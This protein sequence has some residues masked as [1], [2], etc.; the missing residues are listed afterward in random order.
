MVFSSL[1]F[2]YVFLPLTLAVYHL[3]FF[4][5]YKTRRPAFITLSNLVLLLASL[6][7]Y[8]WGQQWYLFVMLFSTFLD[9][10][11]A[12]LIGYGLYGRLGGSSTGRRLSRTGLVMSIA[13]NLAL[14]GY[15]KYAGFFARGVQALGEVISGSGGSFFHLGEIVLPIGISFYTFQTLSYTIDVYRGVVRPNKNLVD[16]ACYVTMF[17]Q[18]VAGPIVRYRDICDQLRHRSIGVAKFWRGI[19]RFS[20]GLAKKVLIANTIAV[21]ADDLFG[22]PVGTLTMEAAWQGAFF[23]ALQIYFDFSGYSDMAIGLGHLL[24]F[25][26]PENFNYPYLADSMRDFWRRWH[27]SLSTWFRDY[28]YIPLGGSR[29]GP[30]RTTFHLAFVFL[31]VGLW[32]GAAGRFVFWGLFHGL[33]LILER[34]PFGRMLVKSGR[35]VRSVY[36]TC[37]VLVGWVFFRSAS[38]EHAF[39]YVRAMFVPSSGSFSWTLFVVQ[40]LNPETL[41]IALVALLGC[42]PAGRDIKTRALAWAQDPASRGHVLFKGALISLSA[43]YPLILLLL[44]TIYLASG[45]HNPFIYFR[46]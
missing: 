2:L 28:V 35:F 42:T 22:A 8:F 12:R 11:S 21:V 7:F 16:Y 32:H 43:A 18:L 40:H 20:I 13:G 31:L 26:F 44:S 34:G 39:A 6:I 27:I 36:V 17:P 3:A 5:F 37:V 29:S 45:T 14:L 23:Y 41:I 10:F 1:V 30:L 46:F 24:G 15:F 4:A 25:S 9:Y 38:L 19:E 33:F